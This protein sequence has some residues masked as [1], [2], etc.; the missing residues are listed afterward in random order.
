MEE[1]SEQDDL[2]LNKDT[3]K[4]LGG[5]YRIFALHMVYCS[6]HRNNKKIIHLIPV[7]FVANVTALL[8]QLY[9]KRISSAK[10]VHSPLCGLVHQV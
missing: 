1:E 7:K 2:S 3:T 6:L 8:L 5:Y 4:L 9:I 10:K